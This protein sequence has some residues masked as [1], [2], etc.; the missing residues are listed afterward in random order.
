[1]AVLAAVSAA[2]LLG[3]GDRLGRPDLTR[4][5]RAAFAVLVAAVAIAA[6]LLIGALLAN[7]FH[8]LYVAQVSSLQTPWYFR[9]GA[10][11]GGAA[12]S[13]L[14]WL[15]IL[16]L[17]GGYLL[18]RPPREAEALLDPALA[19][20]AAAA[21]AFALL[22]AAVDSPF[23]YQAVAPQ[24]GNGLNA[25]L[26][27]GSFLLHP[28][29][30]YTGFVGFTVP[31]AFAMAGLLRGETGD[32]WIRL[33]HRW[34]LT[35]WALLSLGILLGAHWSYHV[36]GWGGYW[37]FDPV[38]NAALLPW[39]VGT[40][41]I[42]SAMVQERRGML[43]VWNAAL[44]SGTYILTLF[45]TF[46]TRS[47]VA[48][49]V[50]TFSQS[51][52]GGWLLAYC[53]LATAGAV[54]LIGSRLDLLRDEREPD[55][56]VSR[57]GAFLLNNVVFVALALTVFVGTV[58]P[59]L[60]P[61]F[62][63]E[64]SIGAPYFRRVTAPLFTVALLLAGIGPLLAWRRAGRREFSRHLLWPLLG[65]AAFALVAASAGVHPLSAVVAFSCAFFAAAA[66]LFDFG[67]A[68][69]ARQQM[70]P[71]GPVTAAWH[72]VNRNPR[73]YGGYLVH[74]AMAVIA[75]GVIASNVYERQYLGVQ[76]PVGGTVAVGPWDLTYEGL[77]AQ[78]YAGAVENYARL[79]L[80]VPGAGVVATLTPG[81]FSGTDQAT[82]QSPTFQPGIRSGLGGDVYTVL[83]GYPA[84]GQSAVFNIYLVPLV[85]WIW[86]GGLLL[87]MGSLWSLWPR[88]AALIAPR[89]SRV[90]ALWSEL[91]YDFR[92]GKTTPADY[93]ALRARFAA[94][95]E[96]ALRQEGGDLAGLPGME[97]R[98]RQRAAELSAR[99]A[100][101]VAADAGAVPR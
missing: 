98:I 65:A 101:G 83:E 50:H 19:V 86:L 71:S 24:D 73:R 80:S 54:Y 31:F 9:V 6:A 82:S 69:I 53:G 33:T 62:G 49:S 26:R 4:A 14:L 41:F 46:V 84:G 90:F 36:L 5:G 68:V 85:G 15:L 51:P 94:E 72:L 22:V 66:V 38:E 28:V 29:V 76:I 97:R 89:S 17:Y 42:H 58:V 47:G 35:A 11:W 67:L 8:I 48:D 79:V 56:L 44:V 40:A 92:M 70:A 99:P 88:R 63:P 74:I 23:V 55:S 25:L 16:T 60:S 27:A 1:M 57:E 91:E 64:I 81:V 95:A 75:F 10:L 39:V 93:A 100:A 78:P 43:K 87:V 77:G 18:A 3:V 2:A 30:I 13:L 96:A 21:G 32:R 12:G 34:A 61:Y 59:I 20:L 37:D 7:D 52:I 45:G